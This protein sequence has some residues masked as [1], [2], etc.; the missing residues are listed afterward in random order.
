MS[1]LRNHGQYLQDSVASPTQIELILLH[2]M[3]FLTV[4]LSKFRF[5]IEQEYTLLQKDTNWPLGWPLGGYPGPQVATTHF[6][7]QKDSTFQHN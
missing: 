5:G 6:L 7:Q 2:Q 4:H 1:R 3:V